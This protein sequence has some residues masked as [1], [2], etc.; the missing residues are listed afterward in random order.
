MSGKRE[1]REGMREETG[2]EPT[3][4]LIAISLLS[5]FARSESSTKG[6]WL[7]ILVYLLPDNDK[8]ITIALSRIMMKMCNK[9]ELIIW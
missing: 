5:C 2:F 4:M 8:T 3:L 9:I 6:A 7:R 1:G